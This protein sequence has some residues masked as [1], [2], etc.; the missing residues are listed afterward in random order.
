ME[1]KNQIINYFVADLYVG[2]IEVFR[3][4]V[5]MNSSLA[6]KLINEHQKNVRCGD[7]LHVCFDRDS[8]MLYLVNSEYFTT[9][10]VSRLYGE[11][12]NRIKSDFKVP[13]VK[14]PIIGSPFST[15]RVRNISCF[16]HIYKNIINDFGD[17]DFVDLPVVEANL[18]KMPMTVKGLSKL[19]DSDRY[20]G[21]Y[22]GNEVPFIEEVDIKGKKH[23]P[24][25]VLLQKPPF[26]LVNISPNAAKDAT[27]KEWV[28]LSGYRDYL[29][30][31]GSHIKDEIASYADLYAIQRHLYLGW[32]FEEVSS[33]MLDSVKDFTSLIKA[34]SLMVDS[35]FVLEE[36]GYSNPAE[37]PYYFTFKIDPSTFPIRIDSI[38][39]DNGCIDVFKQIDDFRIINYDVK[40]GFITIE[41]PV[42]LSE[43][44]CSEILQAVSVP[45]IAKYNRVINMIDVKSSKGTYLTLKSKYP[46]QLAK[47]KAFIEYRTGKDDLDYRLGD[48][49]EGVSLANPNS[50]NIRKISEYCYAY[51]FIKSMCI[52]RGI[53]FKD[54]DVVVGP[55][56]QVLGS[57]VQGGFVTKKSF[58]KKD[59]AYPYKLT[60]GVYITPPLIFINSHSTPSYAEQTKIIIHEYSHYLFSIAHPEHDIEYDGSKLS[61]QRGSKHFYE[62]YKYMNDDDEVLAHKTEIK[63]ALLSGESFDEIIRDKVGGRVTEENYTVALEFKNLV[64]R[65]IKEIEKETY[66]YNTK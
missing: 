45:F 44:I 9:D 22:I 31:S 7:L 2:S 48:G 6:K 4:P 25:L 24:R 61:G 5:T 17:K 30:D 49:A 1:I 58:K 57:G 66:E 59:I 62:W 38:L 29:D 64:N 35:A 15:L 21:G 60:K 34:I 19:Y 65:V 43:V 54:L 63:Y 53:E 13:N 39:D 56:E 11:V 14:T 28:V 32:S 16:S 51:D 12:V 46:K 47:I 55:I 20:M 10:Q 33:F 40:N 36:K 8:S 42:F 27:D 52:D 26:I 18:S 37:C 3:A 50:F 41:T 23:E